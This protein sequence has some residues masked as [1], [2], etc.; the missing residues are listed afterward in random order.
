MYSSQQDVSHWVQYAAGPTQLF[1]PVG[2]SQEVTFGTA[3]AAAKSGSD[4]DPDRVRRL[5]QN[6]DEVNQRN[7]EL[8]RRLHELQQLQQLQLL[9]PQTKRNVADGSSVTCGRGTWP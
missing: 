2:T 1:Q 3:G 4:S 8:E 6:L 5:Q 9:P 7:S